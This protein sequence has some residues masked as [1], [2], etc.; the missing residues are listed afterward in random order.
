[1]IGPAENTTSSGWSQRPEPLP[2]G[3]HVRVRGLLA[4]HHRVQLV[5]E[6]VGQR[7]QDVVAVMPGECGLCVWS[8]ALE[9]SGNSLAGAP[10]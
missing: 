7:V 8:P 5:A 1:M 10:A 9:P 2:V 4:G 3:A 6:F